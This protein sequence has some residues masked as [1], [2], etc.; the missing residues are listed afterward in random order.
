M[1]A[2]I[3]NRQPVRIEARELNEKSADTDGSHT[4][5]SCPTRQ[6]SSMPKTRTAIPTNGWSRK[7]TEATTPPNF[8]QYRPYLFGRHLGAADSQGMPGWIIPGPF[9]FCLNRGMRRLLR[10]Q[11]SQRDNKT[12][13]PLCRGTVERDY[14]TDACCDAAPATRG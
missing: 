2:E 12:W 5:T 11:R 7:P 4:A 1:W 14:G 6:A 3:A 9:R 10:R 13:L 8:R